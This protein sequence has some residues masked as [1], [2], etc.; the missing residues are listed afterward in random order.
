MTLVTLHSLIITPQLDSGGGWTESV[1]GS[2]RQVAKKS[3]PENVAASQ[4]LANWFRIK[5]NPEMSQ[6]AGASL[7]AIHI[8]VTII[9]YLVYGGGWPGAVGEVINPRVIIKEYGVL[10]RRCQKT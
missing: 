4:S 8:D 1:R 5:Q 7:I 10:A 3:N 9:I 2:R 6:P